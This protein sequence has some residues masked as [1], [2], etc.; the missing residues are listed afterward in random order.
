MTNDHRKN[1]ETIEGKELFDGLKNPE[2][3]VR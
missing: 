3:A 1:P 2:E